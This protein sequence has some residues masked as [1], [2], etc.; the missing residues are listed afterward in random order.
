MKKMLIMGPPGA[1]KGTQAEKIIEYYGIPHISTGDMFRAAISNKT[2][3]GLIAKKYIDAGNLVPDEVT[4]GI[5]KERLS[6]PDCKNGFLL[7]GF[8]R[9]LKQAEMFS[10]MLKELDIK[11]DLVLNIHVDSEKLINRII[12]RRICPNCGRTYHITYNKPL[13]EG[14]CDECGSTLIQRKDDNVETVK[15]RLD[16]YAQKT[17]PLINYYKD[18]VYNVD[19]DRDVDVIFNDI[20]KVIGD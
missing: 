20:K 4:V 2:E 7:D 3:V 17:E 8:P 9:D 6:N 13:K 10:D 16:V 14:I 1:G 12:G 15:N 19:G 5:V 11:L 18:L